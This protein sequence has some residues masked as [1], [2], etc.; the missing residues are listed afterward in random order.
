MTSP[1]FSSSAT[2]RQHIPSPQCIDPLE[3][4]SSESLSLTKRCAKKTKLA[5]DFIPGPYTVICGRGRLCTES[6][7]NRYLK[8]LIHKNLDAY[9]KAKTKAEKSEIVATILLDVREK[10]PLG[11]FVKQTEDGLAGWWEVG[12]S[13]AREKIGCIFRDVLH[14]QYK[15]S[16]KSKHERKKRIASCSSSSEDEKKKLASKPVGRRVSLDS[17]DTSSKKRKKTTGGGLAGRTTPLAPQL[18]SSR[19]KLK[20][21]SSSKEMGFNNKTTSKEEE[22]SL[23]YI[24]SMFWTTPV[25]A[26]SSLPSTKSSTLISPESNTT[27]SLFAEALGVVEVDDEFLSSSDDDILN[28][29][30]SDIFD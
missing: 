5:Y 30:F 3:T 9:S 22:E 23:M 24:A 6:P 2:L 20:I 1:M 29:N 10:S 14:T 25:L 11:A 17:F 26:L 16:T 19:R 13:F 18:P 15:S 21:V 8:T 4:T 28:D 7:G 12:D 27:R